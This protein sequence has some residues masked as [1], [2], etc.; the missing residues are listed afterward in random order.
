MHLPWLQ[1]TIFLRCVVEDLRFDSC[2]SC[3][4][5]DRSM[6]SNSVVR[7]RFEAEIEP[8]NEVL[9]LIGREQISATTALAEQD[10]IFHSVAWTVL[11]N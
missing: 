8:E 1:R 3:I 7:A 11:V 4:A 5:F 2:V 6:N 9:V 10:S